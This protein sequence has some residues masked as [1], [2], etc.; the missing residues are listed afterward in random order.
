MG[1]LHDAVVPQKSLDRALRLL[2]QGADV[3]APDDRGQTPLHVAARSGWAAAVRA[4]LDAGADP[5]VPDWHDLTPIDIARAGGHKRA[6]ALMTGTSLDELRLPDRFRR[7]AAEGKVQAMRDL[8]AQNG[9]LVNDRLGARTPLYHAA[10]NGHAAAVDALVDMG[11]DVNAVAELGSGKSALHCL[12]HLHPVGHWHRHPDHAAAQAVLDSL[13]RAGADV[14]ARDAQ[15]KTPL[16]YVQTPSAIAALVEAGA[17]VD[18]RDL[19]GKTPLFGE[20][21]RERIEGLLAAGADVAARDSHGKTALHHAPSLDAARALLAAGADPGARDASGKTAAHYL[22]RGKSQRALAE[23]HAGLDGMDP[24]HRAAGR[25]DAGEVADLLRAGAAAG[26]RDDD[27]KVPL[28]HAIAGNH[29]EVVRL[30]LAA[31]PPPGG[32]AGFALLEGCVL[33]GDLDMLRLL[34]DA[35]IDVNSGDDSGDDSGAV[36][37]A[38]MLGRKAEP[39]FSM[40]LEAGARLTEELNRCEYGYGYSYGYGSEDDIDVD[41]DLTDDMTLLHVACREGSFV[42]AHALLAAGADVQRA[43]AGKTALHFAAMCREDIDDVGAIVSMLLDAGAGAGAAGVHAADGCGWTPLHYAA[44]A[45]NLRAARLLVDAGA[46]AEAEDW[47]GDTPLHN[48]RDARD[49]RAGVAIARLLLERGAEPSPACL[50]YMMD[51]ERADLF[52][53]LL[54]CGADANGPSTAAEGGKVLHDAA[55]GNRPRM[56]AALLARGADVHATNGDGQTPLHGAGECL[57]AIRLLLDAGADALARD[58]EGLTALHY[59]ACAGN[60]AGVRALAAAGCP[61]EQRTVQAVDRPEMVAALVE[62]G[63]RAWSAVPAPCRGLGAAARA[64]WEGPDGDRHIAELARRL[65]PDVRARLHALVLALGAAE[66]RRGFAL[67]HHPKMAIFV[68]AMAA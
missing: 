26:A 18:A 31:G 22:S 23:L 63:S 58:A 52:E 33:A 29:A 17:G 59:A 1:A 3:N 39:A 67:P 43:C 40:L 21:S 50:L 8:A 64:V 4:L 7:A 68:N 44:R 51:A 16:F 10:V 60:V 45:G 53:L 46:D 9:D 54:Q 32:V 48:C 37:C 19:S 36:G 27:G 12:W 13:L 57:E 62:L 55:A 34:L 24:L 61:V 28:L 25:G 20:A 56:V 47:D 38:I 30:L 11:A 65:E 6:V 14:H 15:G 49:Q 5:A 2:R 41:D 66:R 35:G 42:M